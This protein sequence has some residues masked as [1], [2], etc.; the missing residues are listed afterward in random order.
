MRI[1]NLLI[2]KN[3]QF[4]YSNPGRHV[5]IGWVL[6]VMQVDVLLLWQGV[7]IHRAVWKSCQLYCRIILIIFI[8]IFWICFILISFHLQTIFLGF[9]IIFLDMPCS[10]HAAWN[11]YKK[12]KYLPA[13]Q[14]QIL[15]NQ[16]N[17][18]D[19][20]RNSILYPGEITSYEYWRK[21]S[22]ISIVLQLSMHTSSFFI[23][24]ATH[25]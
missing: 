21:T 15:P 18:K 11:L 6:P 24:Y 17:L 13:S 12:H 1:K 9:L 2:M 10:L 25:G 16:E 23:S 19:N 14:A 3:K 5:I 4:S 22:L 7:W 8:K 20:W